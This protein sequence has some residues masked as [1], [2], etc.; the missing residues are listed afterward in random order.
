MSALKI[1]RGFLLAT[2][3]IYAAIMAL[4][5]F[6]LIDPLAVW[7]IVGWDCIA[8]GLSA[9]ACVFFQGLSWK[10]RGRENSK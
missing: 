2:I 8:I 5:Y 7:G 9:A 6:N 10:P 1:S 4:A 3:L